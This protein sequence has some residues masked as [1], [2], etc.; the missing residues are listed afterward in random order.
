MY[1]CTSLLWMNSFNCNADERMNDATTFQYWLAAKDHACIIDQHWLKKVL[2]KT[3]RKKNCFK[4]SCNKGLVLLPFSFLG[5]CTALKKIQLNF[6]QV[7][8]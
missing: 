8:F 7:C 1:R 6:I 2:V 3:L 4:T 5:Q